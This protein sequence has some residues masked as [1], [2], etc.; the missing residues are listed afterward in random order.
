MKRKLLLLAIAALA[1]AVPCV[2]QEKT[3]ARLDGST[4]HEAQI[5]ETVKKLMAGAE[6]PGVGL[7]LFDRGKISYLSAY[8][9][10]DKEKNLPL[11]VDSIMS[12]ASFTKVAFGYLVQ[13]W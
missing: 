6:V 8:G 4:I 3:F 12:G 10:R 2:A 11:T 13:L 1:A 5:N 9:V 7:A